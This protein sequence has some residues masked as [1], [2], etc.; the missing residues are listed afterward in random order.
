MTRGKG[1]GAVYKDS[2]GL[3]TASIELPSHDG[4]RRRKVI[5]SKDKR[6][7]LKKLSEAKRELQTRGDLPTRAMTVEQWFTYWLEHVAVKQLRPRTLAAY[8]STVSRHI[9]PGL[10]GKTRLDKVTPRTIRQVHQK[11]EAEGLSPTYSLNAHAIMA[12]SFLI[13]KREGLIPEPPTAMM[14]R[15]RA[16]HVELDVPTLE[17]SITLLRACAERPDGARWATALLTAA[18]R[19]EVLGLEVDRVGDGLDLSWQLQRFKTTPDGSLQVPPDYEYRHLT[20]GLYLTR[21]KSRAGVRVVPLVEPL[22]SILARHIEAMEPNPW[23]LLFTHNGQP[24]TPETDQRA[25]IKLREELFGPG[26]RMRIHDLRHA[27]VDLLYLAGVPEDLI[28]EIVGHSTRAM[29]RAYKSSNT[30]RKREAL[31]LFG[32]LFNQLA[33]ARTPETVGASPL[34][35]E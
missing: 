29:S 22:R 35:L 18:R 2:R 14:D 23:G 32:A 17:E 21:P 5:R 15:P 16:A 34:V 10:G 28:V 7:V 24:R 19:G 20:G 4:T 9:I 3:W 8:R 25:W 31:E 11:I 27:T 26:R 30:A 6:T 33:P 1:E 12:R 13:A